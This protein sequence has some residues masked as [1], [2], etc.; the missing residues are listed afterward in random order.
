MGISACIIARNEEKNID[1]CLKSIADVV[2]E[3]ILVDTGSSDKTI[4]VAKSYGAKV[5]FRK[6]DN[7]F[8]AARNKSLDMAT[9][10]WILVIDC[11]EVLAENSKGKLREIVT[12]DTQEAFGIDIV[13]IINGVESY[14][15]IHL[16]LFKNKPEY[17]YKGIIH[18]QMY[19]DNKNLEVLR[20]HINFIHY[21]YGNDKELEV[22]KRDRN[23]KI[24]NLVD[25][26]K[27]DGMYYFHLGAE[28]TRVNDHNTASEIFRKGYYIADKSE[29][30]FTQLAQ[31]L[32][33]SLFS[34]NQYK[35]CI[36]YCD[37]ILKQFVDFKCIYFTRA[38]SYIQIRNYSKALL[39]L[40]IYDY[41]QD[42]PERYPVVRHDELNDIKELI[43]VLEKEVSN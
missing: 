1:S 15:S 17:R 27:R 2:D 4:E 14:A 43:T 8:S 28:Y 11:D 42:K 21:G 32:V 33:D 29:P 30:Y 6:W 13:N 39:S 18:E 40:R 41:L 35:E 20:A 9:H 34:N 37:E 38:A 22:K 3:I 23:L 26:D 5:F 10:E 25:E 31:R 7:D 12:D 19:L 36:Q 24:L 16:R